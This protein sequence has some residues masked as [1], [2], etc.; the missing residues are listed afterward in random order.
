MKQPQRLQHLLKTQQTLKT[1]K[2]ASSHGKQQLLL[3][4]NNG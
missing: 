3:C 1:N 4:T 2:E